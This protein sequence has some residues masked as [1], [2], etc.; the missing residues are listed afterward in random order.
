AR[1]G[2]LGGAELHRVGLDLARP[3]VF[4][5]LRASAVVGTA[6]VVFRGVGIFFA[7][8]GNARLV[9]LFDGA[10]LPQRAF[11]GL[12]FLRHRQPLGL[13][14]CLVGP[15]EAVLDQL[16]L[17]LSVVCD[18]FLRHRRLFDSLVRFLGAFA[19]QPHPVLRATVGRGLVGIG[20]VGVGGGLV[21]LL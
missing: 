10:G 21:G 2:V 9:G 6:R 17:V 7:I 12:L 11:G 14:F 20:L 1:L 8:R 4:G 3:F 15:I 5:L 19:E 16:D 13:R 18:S